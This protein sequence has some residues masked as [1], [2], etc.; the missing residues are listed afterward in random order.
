MGAGTGWRWWAALMAASS[1][2]R[3]GE[4][5]ERQAAHWLR[6][7]ASDYG[8]AVQNGRVINQEE[9]D[10]QIALLERA[11]LALSSRSDGGAMLAATRRVRGL[12]D[13]RADGREVS[14]L[15]RAVA[16]RLLLDAGAEPPG[17]PSLERGRAVFE[18]ACA[19]CHG[20]D[21][22]GKTPLA[23]QL[24]PPPADLQNP[25][26]IEDLS[27]Q[28]VALAIEFGIPGT[29]MVPRPELAP[30]ERWDAAFYAVAL[31]WPD[32]QEAPAGP[33]LS[34]GELATLRNQELRGVLIAAGAS[35]EQVDPWMG[36]YRKT[37]PVPPPSPASLARQSLRKGAILGAMDA[38]AA[39]AELQRASRAAAP[40]RRP[41]SEVE[42]AFQSLGQAPTGEQIQAVE[43]ALLRAD[44]RGGA[45]ES[46]R[47]WLALIVAFLVVGSIALG[48]LRRRAR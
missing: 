28:A 24:R 42:R 14:A 10:E 13:A 21:G 34:L 22:S 30:D 6:Y 47:W 31:A 45:P 17:V 40:L 32:V 4:T 11:I 2:A 36:W 43:R 27:P 35:D 38:P 23:A 12:V 44:L 33:A 46:R 16:E 7:V 37:P 18:R 41:G 48:L 5:D 39:Q 19:S 1:L 3:A 9:L 8:G 25:V 26:R 20:S 15:A 29:G